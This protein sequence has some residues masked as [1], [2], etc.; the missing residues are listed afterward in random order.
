L[1]PTVCRGRMFLAVAAG[2][3]AAEI[4]PA[5]VAKLVVV[6]AE[7]LAE[8]GAAVRNQLAAGKCWWAG[9]LLADC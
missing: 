4:L 7:V 9:T 1:H 2:E 3:G 6:V 8:Q 5:A